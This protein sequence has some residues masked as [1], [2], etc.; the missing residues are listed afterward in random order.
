MNQ[1]R[2]PVMTENFPVTVRNALRRSPLVWEAG[3]KSRP[4]HTSDLTTGTPVTALPYEVSATK[5]WPGCQYSVT[6]VRWQV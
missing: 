6:G 3:F 1:R 4:G 2:V 5:G